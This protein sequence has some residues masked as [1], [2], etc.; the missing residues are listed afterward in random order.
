MSK[1][2]N[3]EYQE[4]ISQDSESILLWLFGQKAHHLHKIQVPYLPKPYREDTQKKIKKNQSITEKHR[5]VTYELE[6]P[7]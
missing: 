5:N 3:T 1:S 6:I 4:L 7:T 2:H